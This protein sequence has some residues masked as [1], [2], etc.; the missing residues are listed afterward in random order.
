M[1]VAPDIA[2]FEE[3]AALCEFESEATRAEAED[4]AAQQQ[5]WTDAVSDVS[6]Y[7]AK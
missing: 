4:L 6:S 5:G 2:D 3:R 7:G 1:R